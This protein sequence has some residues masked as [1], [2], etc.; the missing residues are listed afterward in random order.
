[1]WESKQEQEQQH[2]QMGCM[3][4]PPVTQYP[5]AA[6][7]AGAAAGPERVHDNPA[8]R[9]TFLCRCRSMS[10]SMSIG[11]AWQPRQSHIIHLPLQKQ[12]QQQEQ[13]E[14]MTTPPATQISSVQNQEQQHEQRECMTTPPATQPSC[15]T[16]G[17]GAAAWADGVHDNPASHTTLFCSCRS[18]SSSRRRVQIMHGCCGLP[19][20]SA[21]HASHRRCTRFWQLHVVAPVILRECPHEVL[22]LPSTSFIHEVHI[23]CNCVRYKVGYPKT[24]AIHMWHGYGISITYRLTSLVSKNEATLVWHGYGISVISLL[25]SWVS[26]YIGHPHMIWLWYQHHI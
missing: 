21:S 3:T 7:E 14:C 6:A 23:P 24:E 20:M 5:C 16:A 1:M 26:K 19:C 12:E 17:A 10:S 4:T 22:E 9:T 18:R 15:V 11:G 25:E 13:R 2:E 8:S